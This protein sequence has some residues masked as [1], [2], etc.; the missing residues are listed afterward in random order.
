MGVAGVQIN[1]RTAMQLAA[2]WGSVSLIADSIATLPIKQ[3]RLVAGEPREMDPAP[4][5]QKPWSEM[6][7]RDFI[8]QGSVSMLLRGTLWGRVAS[9][10]QN[11]Y[12]EQ[13]QLVHP[14]HAR[15]VRLQSAEGLRPAG[16]LQVRYW[17]EVQQWERVTRKMALSFPESLEGL[18]PIAYMRQV[19]GVA[20]AQ[21]AYNGSFFANSAHPHGV[22]EVQDDL[23]EDETKAMAASWNEA[24]QGVSNAFKPAVLTGGATW[25]PITMS[26]QDVQFLQQLGYSASVISGYIYRIPPHMV[27][28][29]DK[30]T[31][32]GSGIEQQELGFV[33]NTLLIWLCRW[34]DLMT[35]WLPPRQFVT[36]DLSQRLRGDTLQR[37]QGYQIARICGFMNNL[38]VMRAEGMQIPTDQTLVDQLSDYAAPLNSSPL[39]VGGPQGP[40]GDK[41]N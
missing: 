2:V 37:F 32:W 40:G 27:G 29:Q 5:I 36:F 34:E 18:N 30:D 13:V 1:D 26:L 9:W 25:K 22:I 12:P 21:D 15:I 11:L 41:A 8:T 31:S 16:S 4:V 23:D 20:Y 6:D 3:Y 28:Q 24:H 33:R 35:S 17:N 39:K 19:L 38:D 14:D 10:D 7:R